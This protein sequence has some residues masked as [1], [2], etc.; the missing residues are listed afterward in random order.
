[1]YIVPEQVPTQYGG[2]SVD[3]YECSPEFT[4]DDPVTEI[5]VKPA[6]KQ[7]VEI[8]INE[9]SYITFLQSCIISEKMHTHL[10]A[11]CGGW[12]VCYWA[13]FVPKHGYMVLIQKTK[14]MAPND[15]PVVSDSFTISDLG[16]ELISTNIDGNLNKRTLD[17]D[18]M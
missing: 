17:T 14:K 8:I 15:E 7:L 3:F 5:T 4:I 13:E 1:M 2:I 12:E 18:N 16:V 9:V 11:S 6:T 10:G